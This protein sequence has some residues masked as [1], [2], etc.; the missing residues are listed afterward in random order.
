MGIS[1]LALFLLFVPAIAAATG[2][3]FGVQAGAGV[4]TWLLS[5]ESIQ[6][7]GDPEWKIPVYAFSL[8]GEVRLK[9]WLV[10][11][12]GLGFKEKSV[13]IFD[14]GGREGTMTL[15]YL[16]APIGVV[17]VWRGL[18]VG[19]GGSGQWMVYGVFARN[20]EPHLR[21]HEGGWQ[22]RVNASGLLSVG[23][24]I[25][26]SATLVPSIEIDLHLLRGPVAEILMP[27]NAMDVV[28]PQ[29]RF[30]SVMFNVVFFPIAM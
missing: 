20:S 23:Y 10:V 28:G 17:C 7:Y 4:S 22:K 18:R 15:G 3:R 8:R 13:R 5:E 25:G 14:R 9:E 26:D 21:M 27:T 16:Q 11:Y 24:E 19:V 2:G 6:F 1:S 29:P 30:V 12:A